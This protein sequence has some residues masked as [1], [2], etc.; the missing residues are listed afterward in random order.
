MDVAAPQEDR[1]AP[2]GM[3]IATAHHQ[4]GRFQEAEAGYRA[5][6]KV[7][8]EHPGANH[9]LGAM[10][11]AAKKVD[12]ACFLIARAIAASP[13]QALFRNS[14]GEALHAAGRFHEARVAYGDAIRLAP[15]DPVPWS[16]LGL[17][18]LDM[19]WMDQAE[20]A[21]LS[22]VA[23]RPTYEKAVRNL[24]ARGRPEA[25]RRALEAYLSAAPE[26]GIGARAQLAALGFGPVPDTVSAAH[27]DRIY[28]ARA[29]GWPSAPG[30]HAPQ[31]VAGALKARVEG[32]LEILDGGCGTGLVGPLVRKVASRLVGVDVSAPMLNRARQSRIYDE[33]H[34]DD[35]VGHM[36][37]HPQAYDAVVCAAT[38]I[39]FGDLQ[40]FFS[41][42]AQALRVGGLL[43]FTAFPNEADPDAYAVGDVDTARV[44]LFFHGRRYI[45]CCAQAAG[46]AP[47]SM[48][49]EVHE[50]REGQPVTGLLAVYRAG[51]P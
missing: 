11:L 3:S 22:A 26:D 21:L 35:L 23:L 24:V 49:D 37:T 2:D 41:A 12:D 29:P 9:N 20:T 32:R 47:L 5:I 10:A 36:R 48:S 14:L 8:P 16:N 4:A 31:L 45:E 15:E 27:I 19:G 18:L 13:N 6:L 17:A 44:G 34:Q 39:H 51:R 43:I 46:F 7:Q 1:P 25:A 30:Y 28:A 33:L 38:V 40:P 50:L 42:A